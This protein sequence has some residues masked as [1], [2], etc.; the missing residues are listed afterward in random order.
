MSMLVVLSD[1]AL[2]TIAG[3]FY[4]IRRRHC[5]WVFIGKGLADDFF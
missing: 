5:Y 2:Q 3:D 4:S 1:C